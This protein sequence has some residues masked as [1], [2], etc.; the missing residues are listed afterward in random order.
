[1]LFKGKTL[2]NQPLS[3]WK[4]IYKE[5]CKY[6]QFIIDVRK[7]DI[8]N[9]ISL[10]QMAYFHTVVIPAFVNHTGDSP[11][12]WENKLKLEQG[13]KWFKP[14]TITVNNH[15]YTVIPSKTGL[16][17]KDFNEWLQNIMDFAQTLGFIIPLPNKDWKTEKLEAKR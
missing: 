4:A 5:C 10:Q 1:M 16:S 6:E 17:T 3:A 15:K 2:N 12:Y 14:Q 11:K 13:S 8:E 9:E 7:Y